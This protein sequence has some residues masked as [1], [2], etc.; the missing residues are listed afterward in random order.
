M[1][2]FS[3]SFAHVFTRPQPR[4]ERSS[5]PIV[6]AHATVHDD[7][8]QAPRGPGWFDSSWELRRGLDVHE[9]WFGDDSLNGWIESFLFAQRASGRTAS[10]SASTAIA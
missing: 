5:A 9:G 2:R 1:A 3:A 4:R 10:P 8:E 7:L 6:E